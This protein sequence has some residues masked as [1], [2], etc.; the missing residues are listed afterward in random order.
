LEQ[1]QICLLS[2]RKYFCRYTCIHKKYKK[3]T[4]YF[5][6][7]TCRVIS[8]EMQ[9]DSAKAVQST[10][11]TNH[12][13]PAD[14]RSREPDKPSS[15]HTYAPQPPL[16]INSKKGREK[17]ITSTKS[18]D[19][20]RRKRRLSLASPARKFLRAIEVSFASSVPLQSASVFSSAFSVY[21]TRVFSSSC[22]DWMETGR[23]RSLFQFPFPFAFGFGSGCLRSSLRDRELQGGSSLLA[24]NRD[25]TWSDCS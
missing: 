24:L 1:Q 18:G 16:R 15:I 11:P 17:S 21:C 13:C 5:Y 4:E 7:K 22:L 12:M 2:L 20:N 10:S 3:Y 19:P 9:A 14:Q 23:N 6:I 8:V 25:Y